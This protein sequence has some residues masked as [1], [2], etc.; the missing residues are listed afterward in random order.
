MK[1]EFKKRKILL[2]DDDEVLSNSIIV[3]LKK[4]GYSVV[5]A[6]DGVEALRLFEG[7]EF[8]LIIS[9]I[10]MPNMDGITLLGKIRELDQAVPFVFISGHADKEK[11]IAAI[12]HGARDIIEK[13]FKLKVL[14]DLINLVNLERDKRFL[15]K[16]LFMTAKLASVGTLAAGV[17]HEVN[18]PL[19]IIRGNLELIKKRLKTEDE[20]TLKYLDSTFEEVL[21]IKKITKDLIEYSRAD[22]S[23]EESSFDAKSSI[24]KS[25]NLLNEM[26]NKDNLVIK[27]EFNASEYE[28]L[29]SEGNFNHIIMSILSNAKDS[30]SDKEGELHIR[31]ENE[32]GNLIIEVVDSGCGIPEENLD[33]VFDAFFTTKGPSGY[34]GLGLSLSYS[35]IKKMNGDI[36]IESEVNFGTKVRIELP[37][38]D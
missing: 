4:I 34:V 10:S 37:L 17:A 9:D 30:M 22:G 35:Y 16:Q 1:D 21:R 28:I 2:V 36:R 14:G 18:N 23:L 5:L 26:Y 19:A 13:P 31:T 6:V 24:L 33:K 27:S 25:I 3:Y 11:A 38:I 29:G 32:N 15:E 8:D 12:K 7:D 20:V